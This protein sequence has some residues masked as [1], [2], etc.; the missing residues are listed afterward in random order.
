[1]AKR[2]LSEV[3]LDTLSEM[4]A[5]APNGRVSG[6]AL[7]AKLAWKV[8]GR[9]LKIRQELTRQGKVRA[10][11]GGAGGAL[12]PI[13]AVVPIGPKPLRAFVSY[14]HADAKLKDE[15]LKH[16]APLRRLG[17]VEH[18]HDGDISVGEK[19][20]EAIWNQLRNADLVILLVTADFIN[21][22]YC[23]DRELTAAVERHD[24]GE[25]R[26]VPII[27]RNCLW[28]DLS[29]GKIQAALRGK[30]VRGQADLDEA[31]TEVAKEIKAVAVELRAR[32]Q[33]A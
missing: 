17:L 10:Y 26:I 5:A 19:W 15:L 2:S 3:F 7:E 30:A 29:F 6:N 28:H 4:A 22:E 20:E 33:A 24:A 8:E 14:C 21:S 18:W 16:L 32:A 1:M 12:E 23:Y 27:G 25:T 11:P 9:Y 13:K 31:L